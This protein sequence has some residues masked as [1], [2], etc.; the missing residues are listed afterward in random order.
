MPRMFSNLKLPF[1]SPA[2]TEMNGKRWMHTQKGSSLIQVLIT[3]VT[4]SLDR[5]ELLTTRWRECPLFASPWALYLQ[6]PGHGELALD[7]TVKLGTPQLD[8]LSLHIQV[9]WVLKLFPTE[10]IFPTQPSAAL[11]LELHSCK[12][13]IAILQ[14]Y[15]C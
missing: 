7:E 8:T 14:F 10:R 2:E 11:C 1:S 5:E 15:V 6:V 4:L 12:I 9:S 13:G 3:S